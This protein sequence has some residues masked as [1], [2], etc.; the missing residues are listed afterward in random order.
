[1]KLDGLDE[2]IKNMEAIKDE[3][4]GDPL[5][6]SLRKALTPIVNEAKSLAPVKTGRLRDAIKTRPLPA[7]DLPAGFTDGQELF[8]VSSR[9]KDKDAPDNA[10]YW[11]FVEF[12]STAR[13]G[14]D[15]PKQAFLS[16][17]FDSKRSEAIKVFVDEM[18]AQLEKNVE[19]INRQ[20]T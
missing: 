8:V 15:I 3:L 7:D 17:A 11:H 4:K 20:K 1:M 2:I 9:K 13:N 6:A 5:R 19:R 10:W 12:G 16:P 14:E 18:R